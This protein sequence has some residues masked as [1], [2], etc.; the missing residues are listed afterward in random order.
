MLRHV[1]SG[2]ADLEQS[3][4]FCDA[5]LPTPDC[6]RVRTQADYAAPYFVAFVINRDGCR[7]EA[8]TDRS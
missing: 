3:A 5:F 7:N 6:L 8:V 1:P 2:V 4:R